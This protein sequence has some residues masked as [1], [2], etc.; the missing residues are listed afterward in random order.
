ML[1]IIL[2]RHGQTVWNREC[3]FQGW[4][5][6][7]LT[8]LGVRQAKKVAKFL[9]EKKIDCIFSS[10]L[11]RAKETAAFIIQH[12]P[13]SSVE[14]VEELRELSFGLLEGKTWDE[15]SE[16][17]PDIFGLVDSKDAFLIPHPHGESFEQL[18]ERVGKFLKKILRLHDKTVLFV[19]HD[20]V[21]RSIL[22]ILYC[23]DFE[24]R[25]MVSQP[26]EIVYILRISGDGKKSCKWFNVE[27]GENGSGFYISSAQECK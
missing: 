22:Q 18:R 21:G 14:F 24:E 10:D 1:E 16:D 11:L 27:T 15:A 12:H 5:D 17:V 2:A 23:L 7:P 26:H 13:E 3:R 4:K 6:T 20:G 25:G 9:L 8:P 19:S